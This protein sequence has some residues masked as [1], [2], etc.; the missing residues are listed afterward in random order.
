[1]ASTSRRCRL[2]CFEGLNAMIPYE[3]RFE[4]ARTQ[5][6]R[7]LSKLREAVDLDETEL[8]RDAMIQRF[9]FTY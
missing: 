2:R 8:I 1:M 7:A 6:G 9:E 5:F 3:D 4:I